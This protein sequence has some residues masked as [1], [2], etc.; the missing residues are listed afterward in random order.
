M[1]MQ[2]GDHV[3]IVVD[4]KE[5]LTFE[6]EGLQSEHCVFY[7]FLWYGLLLRW[8]LSLNFIGLVLSADRLVSQ[9]RVDIA[10]R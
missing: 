8:W 1:L 7:L 10:F 9:S 3:M 6:V 5:L 4:P 2:T